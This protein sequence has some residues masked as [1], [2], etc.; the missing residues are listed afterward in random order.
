[1]P[2]CGEGK[3]EEILQQVFSKIN[4]GMCIE[5]FILNVIGTFF[6]SLVV[7]RDIRQQNMKVGTK[8]TGLYSVFSLRFA[9]WAHAA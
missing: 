8:S 6:L 2:D 9:I 4:I 5:I 1:M 3:S 7:S